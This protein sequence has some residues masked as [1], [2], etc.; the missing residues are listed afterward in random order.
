MVDFPSTVSISKWKVL[1][2]AIALAAALQEL[3]G[4]TIGRRCAERPDRQ[5]G[6]ARRAH[7]QEHAPG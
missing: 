7:S 3:G 5:Y 2:A 6:K 1:S 4:I